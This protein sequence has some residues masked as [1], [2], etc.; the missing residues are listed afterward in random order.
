MQYI[1]DLVDY[2]QNTIFLYLNLYLIAKKRCAEKNIPFPDSFLSLEELKNLDPMDW[3]N[4][5]KLLNA[6]KDIISFLNN[7][8]IGK[9]S[10]P[11]ELQNFIENTFDA[12]SNDGDFL[13]ETMARNRNFK[14]FMEKLSLVDT[15][16]AFE[17]S[18]NE[19][20][21]IEEMRNLVIQKVADAIKK[22]GFPVDGKKLITNYLKAYETNK[23]EAYKT[24]TTNPAMFAPLQLDQI[25][26]SFLFGKIK[27]EDGH[28]I[29]KELGI[30][31]KHLKI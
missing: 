10:S 14:T 5:Q 27:P 12:D 11:E 16:L 24:L 3:E 4:M 31:L 9:T 20:C 30:F 7:L 2:K 8:G 13:R 18:K 22:A 17:E 15:F 25:K 28:R 29:N 26:K 23:K 6:G 21:A 1:E 19:L